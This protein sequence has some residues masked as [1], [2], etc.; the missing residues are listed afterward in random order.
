MVMR[1]ILLMLAFAVSGQVALLSLGRQ[2]GPISMEWLG[3]IMFGCLVGLATRMAAPRALAL[4]V[5]GTPVFLFAAQIAQK[6]FGGFGLALAGAFGALVMTALTAALGRARARHCVPV[7][8][9]AGGSVWLAMVLQHYVFETD[10]Y[11]V[12]LSVVLW[13]VIVG[14]LLVVAWKRRAG[15]DAVVV[16]SSDQKPGWDRR[17]AA[18][19]AVSVMAIVVL[20][21]WSRWFWAL[22]DGSSAGHSRVSGSTMPP[23]QAASLQAGADIPTETPTSIT[24][25]G[26]SVGAESAA[27]PTATSDEGSA[28]AMLER[29]AR[30]GDSAAMV[31][32]GW[33]LLEGRE[34]A[35]DPAAAHGWFEA[36]A[37]AGDAVA[38]NN[39]AWL[40]ENGVGTAPSDA[41]ADGWYLRAAEAGNA[42]AMVNLADLYLRGLGMPDL[43]IE[44]KRRLHF[45][46]AGLGSTRDRPPEVK[47]RE[48]EA[49]RWLLRASELGNSY[50]TAELARL[51]LKG[52][53]PPAPGGGRERFL[54]W[55]K[56]AAEAGEPAGMRL[57]AKAYA[58]GL[59][60]ERDP[61]LALEWWQRAATHG[62]TRSM[63]DLADY[64]Y[65]DGPQKDEGHAREFLLAAA[66]QGDPEAAR[67]VAYGLHNG[68]GGFA[69]DKAA[70]L[71]WTRYAADRGDVQATAWIASYLEAGV[72]GYPKNPAGALAL[73]RRL[74]TS[75]DPNAAWNAEQAIEQIQRNESSARERAAM[76]GD[77]AGDAAVAA[78]LLFSMFAASADPDLPARLS[79]G[80]VDGTALGFLAGQPS[81]SRGNCSYVSRSFMTLHGGR[82]FSGGPGT[83]WYCP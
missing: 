11:Q 82:A 17:A 16:G 36:A 9:A 63:L 61:V 29:R 81:E 72:N 48:E 65:A 24:A 62:H 33:L 79:T 67:R 74:A 70:A 1:I 53:L 26:P 4:G 28:P 8:L 78:I 21:A 45:F 32:L 60:T 69:Q 34:V 50:A 41:L 5:S 56:S 49:I 30:S 54:A 22:T 3:P 43:P 13:Q 14:S 44:R 46:G 42:Q 35:R 10:R 80:D 27:E 2:I 64:F 47:R 71:E 31:E 52:R 73:W 58:E 66:E 83:R 19:L 23:E 59:G 7:A 37:R 25:V 15:V 77:R 18:V 76:T 57:L 40:Y 39:V 75:P 55:A 20:P 12:L 51:E 68:V 38:M 6:D